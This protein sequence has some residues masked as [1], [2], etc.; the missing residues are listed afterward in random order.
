[1]KPPARAIVGHLVWG[2]DGGAWAVWNVKPFPHAHTSPADKLAVHSRLRGLLVS[3]PTE[4]LL[5]SVCEPVD[6]AE[7]VARMAEGV[8][9]D[10]HATW[11][12]VCA[13]T[14][15][16]L[17]DLPLRR[18][19]FYVAALL[20]N[21]R[22]PVREVL[23]DAAAE[24]SAAFG[25]PTTGIRA[26]EL[27]AR[28][29]Q[30]RELEIR[31][32]QRVE[33]RPATA[34]E[35]CW[36][37]ARAL[38]RGGD[39][40]AYD[41]RWEPPRGRPDD[42]RRDDD[43]RP[44]GVL[45]HLTDAV[46]KE[47]GYPDDPGRPRHR[48]Y[49]RIDG[50]GP[51]TYQTVLAMADMPHQF[52]YPDGGGEWLFHA[53]QVG[54]P[55][56]WAVRVRSVDNPT[57]QAKVRRKHRDLVG[58]IDE[59]DGELTGA[60]PQLAAAIQAIEDERTALGANPT[61]PEL[62]VT[63]LLSLASDDL[64]ELEEQAAALGALFKPHEY[65]LGRPTGGQVALLRSML[66]G[67]RAAPVCNDYTQFMLARDL[68]AGSPFCGSDV[69]DPTGLLLGLS[70]DGGNGTP[71]LFDPAF[72][73]QANA[74][75]SLAAVGRLGSGKSFLL[76]R[77][78]WDTVAR[79]G[80]VV[81]ID[82]TR[83]GEY[84][85]FAAAVPGRVQVVRV[86]AGADVRLDPF[87]TFHIDDART[88][89]LGV[90]SLLAGC[91]A[92]SEEGAVLAEAVDRVADQP[93]PSLAAV[94]DELVLMGDHPTQP[95]GVARALARRLAHHRRS[96]TGQIAFG[97][98]DPVSLDA[99]FIV[100]W[101]PNLALPDRETL[102]SDQSMRL[103]LP[104]QILGQA[105]LY[106]IAAV[107]RHVVFRDPSRFAA[108]L[109]DE[110][111]AL[112]ASPH[113]QSLLIEGVR[114]G[115][116]HNGAIWLASQHP[117]DFAIDELED[118]LG[119]R[120]VFR[121]ARRAIP[122]AL[123]FL[124]VAESVDAGTTLEH[125]LENGVCFYRDVRDRVGLVQVLPPIV[126]GLGEAFDTAPR[127]SAELPTAE[128]AL[129]TPPGEGPTG[130]VEPPA[131][132]GGPDADVLP[133]AHGEADDD[134][135]VGAGGA[136]EPDAEPAEVADPPPVRAEVVAPYEP[137]RRPPAPDPVAVSE[138]RRAARA[139]RRTPLARALAGEEEA[140]R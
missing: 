128:A 137:A 136:G 87:R 18:R 64:E 105:L 65:G 110:A 132:D 140:P 80:Q 27:A 99:D 125:G 22:R 42:G 89:A 76:K 2:T 78:C 29:R 46:V 127:R 82:R 25:I 116:K 91:T 35:L 114:D 11:G 103:M 106:L 77:L 39:E 12:E 109:Y 133:A 135:P 44:Q 70:L 51:P 23:R 36:L 19:R 1:M 15:E 16:F 56:D 85:R 92:H 61:E 34:G 68:A 138:A 115:R 4:S 113:G 96:P 14:G 49:V 59:Y 71:V 131:A 45:A 101:L 60:P 3:L 86:E 119:S 102:M 17:D 58:Q 81:T 129:A 134:P 20:P 112:L 41:P 67:T 53:D 48:R 5:L 79:G 8:D 62:Q 28:R 63:V 75:P 93:D 139:R 47:G 37:Y 118:L 126:P 50:N 6:A 120:F 95:D 97:D 9:L 73:P 130:A 33:L 122:A 43:V 21:E 38:R 84:A 104:E 69:G 66:P 117:N 52:V 31:L 72:G 107:G 7:V 108:A 94:L 124:G 88:V 40:P 10:R 100:F 30:A 26:A 98:G 57:A 54:F 24:V 111:W 123:R 32:A 121:Q 74:S 90:L 55:V 13:A 83:S